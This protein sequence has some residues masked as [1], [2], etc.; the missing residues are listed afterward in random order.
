MNLRKKVFLL[1]ALALASLSSSAFAATECM[2]QESMS[3]DLKFDKTLSFD[4]SKWN[5]P[6]SGFA[7]VT[8]DIQATSTDHVRSVCNHGQDGQTLQGRDQ[9]AGEDLEKYYTEN[10]NQYLM[11]HTSLKGL[12]YGVKI[13]NPNCADVSGYLPPDQS[14]APLVDVGD[15]DEKSCMNNDNDWTFSIKFFTGPEFKVAHN[16]SFN[17]A[18]AGNHGSFRI[19]GAGDDVDDRSVAVKT[20]QINGYSQ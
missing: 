12:Y 2:F 16:T 13:K 1:S 15:D 14:Y 6:S 20:V 7:P 3:V 9:S 5:V 10:G 11:Y 8:G 18:V 19:S 4:M 17:S